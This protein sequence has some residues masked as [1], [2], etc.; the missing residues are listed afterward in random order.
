MTTYREQRQALENVR[1]REGE[2]RRVDCLFCGGKKTLTLSRKQ[3]AFL[4]NC[5]KASCDAKGGKDTEMS[6]ETIR[7]RLNGMHSNED[8]SDLRP[9]PTHLSRPEHHDAAMAYLRQTNSME[10]YE[11]KMVRVRYSPSEN[12]VLFIKGNEEGGVGRALDRRKPKWKAYGDTSGLFRVGT[13]SIAVV[14]ED[15]ASACSVSRLVECSG[16]SLLGTHATTLHKAQ[17]REFSEVIIALDK[18]ASKKALKLQERLQARVKTRVVYLEEDLKYLT[19]TE[20][21]GLIL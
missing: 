21:R 14:V 3:G 9:F 5:Y 15:V 18:D 13:G 12:R 19:E 11:N 2:T 6:A 7:N 10:A 16:C 1:L 8:G 17:L 20:V 4:W